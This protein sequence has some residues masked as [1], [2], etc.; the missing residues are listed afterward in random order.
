MSMTNKSVDLIKQVWFRKKTNQKLITIPNDCDIEVG[1]FVE[2]TKK[3][4]K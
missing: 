4:V 1:D 2:I 3:K